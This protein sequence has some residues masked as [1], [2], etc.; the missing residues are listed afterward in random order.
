[1]ANEGRC[2]PRVCH[3][4]TR[5]ESPFEPLASTPHE[6]S[7]EHFARFDSLTQLDWIVQGDLRING[8]HRP[9]ATSARLKQQVPQTSG[10]DL[11]KDS[12]ARRYR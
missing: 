1:M 3:G 4:K 12:A 2:L 8:I 11:G 7:G 10:I 6:E 9:M 5:Y